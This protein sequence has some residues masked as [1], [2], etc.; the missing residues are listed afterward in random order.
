MK[1]RPDARTLADQAYGTLR[2][3]ILGGALTP[4]EKL[5]PIVL[6]EQYEIGV[7]PLREALMRLAIERLVT[8]EP[9]RGFR[10][11][12]ATEAGLADLMQARRGIERLCLAQSIAQGDAAWEAEITAAFTALSAAKLPRSRS[13]HAAF[14]RWEAHHRRFHFALIAACESQ[15]LLGF[16]NVLADHSERYRRLRLQHRRRRDAAVRDINGEHAAIMRAVLDRNE[17]EATALMDAHLA[18][19]HRAVQGLL[20]PPTLSPSPSSLS[21]S[22]S[23]SGRGRKRL[24]VPLA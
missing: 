14:E 4:G 2:G 1:H 24:K 5:R 10:V 21:P 19:T 9:Q 17:P 13:D 15:W 8:G 20:A 18:A 23:P 7:T 22:P 16:W 6:Q 3:A 12:E 11:T